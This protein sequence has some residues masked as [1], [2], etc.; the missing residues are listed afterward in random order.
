[1]SGVD[2][3]PPTWLLMKAKP[4]TWFLIFQEDVV[5]QNCH[6][7]LAEV[8]S[9]N[10]TAV[11]PNSQAAQSMASSVEQAICHS[12]GSKKHP[13][14]E[15][16]W[17]TTT[18]KHRGH[19]KPLCRSNVNALVENKR[20]VKTRAAEPCD[21]F[22]LRKLRILDTVLPSLPHATSCQREL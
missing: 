12:S 14:Q 16:A 1:M 19:A 10:H 7:L 5:Y 20:R 17:E 3:I 8:M 9:P 18:E 13:V 15:A 6:H 4:A 21:G 22:V 2:Q 11:Y